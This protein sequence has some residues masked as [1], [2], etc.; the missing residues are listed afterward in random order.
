[1]V[2]TSVKKPQVLTLFTT[3]LNDISIFSKQS[4]TSIS[5]TTDNKHRKNIKLMKKHSAD[6]FKKLR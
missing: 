1:M 5:V 3:G 6:S 2:D 4:K